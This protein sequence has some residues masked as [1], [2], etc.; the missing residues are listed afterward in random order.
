MKT[1]VIAWWSGGI[2]SAVACHFA[3]QTFKNVAVVFID[4]KNEDKDTYR[5]LNDCQKWYGVTIEII[6]AV[7]GVNA[8]SRPFWKDI[9][10][11]WTEYGS[12]NTAHGA[13]C[14]TE[15]KRNMREIY[16]DE[17]QDFAQIFGFDI[18][19]V[20]RHFNM[21]K[22]Y[23]EINAISPLI[24][25]RISKQDAIKIINNVSIEIPRVYK[26]GFRNNNCFQTGCVKGGIGYWQK[27]QKEF[28]EK[29]EKM[30]QMEHFITNMKQKPT[31]ICKDQ[32]K[33]GGL[34]FLK[35]HPSYPEMKDLSMMKGRE[36]ESLI[37]CNG[38][39]ATT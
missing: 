21:R 35:P 39:C 32:S 26:Y 1:R 5:F 37:E 18:S 30:A 9:Q 8:T 17:K 28:P 11:V 6:S 7:T 29:F 15:L 36:V 34:V 20:K 22:N 38:F 4:T 16:Q 27:M 23:P 12:L 24:D 2:A 33:R 14:S 13:I 31:T 19:E 10:D 3:L 25:N